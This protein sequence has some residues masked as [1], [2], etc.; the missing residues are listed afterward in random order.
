MPPEVI[1]K[2]K[3]TAAIDIW[4]AGV[5]LYY[6]ATGNLP[7]YDESIPT[8][9]QKIVYSDPTIPATVPPDLA[10]LLK[11]MLTKRPENR[12]T[13]DSIKEHP[14]FSLSEYQ[15]INEFCRQQCSFKKSI[16]EI[17]ID[18]EITSRMKEMNINISNL[19]QKLFMKNYS[20]STSIY[21]MLRRQKL[22]ETMRDVMK[23]VPRTRPAKL[24]T[25]HITPSS[26][27]IP[28]SIQTDF[29][30]NTKRSLMSTRILSEGKIPHQHPP[31]TPTPDSY[32][33]TK[34]RFS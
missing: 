8:I 6:L 7:F 16:S 26:S 22:I 14:W 31:S 4:S 33:A 19:K 1:K 24:K 25:R 11:R 20:E 3:Y 18:T 17:I 2:Q 5:L 34:E 28:L 30:M 13:L 15:R 29:T 23:I 27:N 32:S 9:L 12:I 10:D 21:E